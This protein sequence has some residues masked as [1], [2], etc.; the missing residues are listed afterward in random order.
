MQ[1]A[2]QAVARPMPTTKTSFSP[3]P[4]NAKAEVTKTP[5]LRSLLNEISY[6]NRLIYD[7]LVVLHDSIR[8]ISPLEVMLSTTSEAKDKKECFCTELQYQ[9]EMSQINN[10]CLSQIVQHLSTLI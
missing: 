6:Q 5:E 3:V 8:K 9:V 7:N 2:K 4:E 10:S 1:K